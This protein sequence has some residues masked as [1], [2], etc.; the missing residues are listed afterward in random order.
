[1]RRRY[2][3]RSYYKGLGSLGLILV[4]LAV[5]SPIFL[6]IS[7]LINLIIENADIVLG[8]LIGIIIIVALIFLIIIACKI[9]DEKQLEFI[10]NHSIAV[11]QLA[12][13]N[14]QYYFKIINNFDCKFTYD[15]E[16]FYHEISPKDYLIYQLQYKYKEVKNALNDANENKKLYEEYVKEVKSI[17]QLNTYDVDQ[18]P[19]FRI[20]LAKKE[21]SILNRS[22]QKP[23]TDFSIVVELILTTINGYYRTS[24]SCYF[25]ADDINNLLTKITDKDNGFYNDDEIWQSI[26]RVERG[27]VTNKLRFFVYDRDG[28]RCVKCG[29]PYDLEVDHIFPVSKGGK[30]TPDNLQTLC[31]RC[32]VAKSNTIE[33]GSVDPKA[34]R[35]GEITCCPICGATTVVKYGKYGKFLS[36]S[37]FPKCKFTK[38]I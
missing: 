17:T 28:H 2:R 37:S 7:K 19:L 27:K 34:K 9:I 4:I 1:M 13:I 26:C 11:E 38:K 15:N 6:L 5:L 25:C 22:V 33:Y 30:S 10:K 16:N 18:L 36:C 23:K 35:L 31:H 20:G 8:V 24:K 32:N 12:K 29:S 21:K 14:Q 3:S